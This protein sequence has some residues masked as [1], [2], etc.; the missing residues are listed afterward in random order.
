VLDGSGIFKLYTP[1]AML[2]IEIKMVATVRMVSRR[3]RLL[4]LIAE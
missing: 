1:I 4:A 3:L 2:G